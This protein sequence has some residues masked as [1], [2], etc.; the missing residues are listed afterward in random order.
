MVPTV[1]QLPLSLQSRAVSGREPWTLAM[2]ASS[3]RSV[4]MM[5]LSR[6]ALI[7]IL[8]DPGEKHTRLTV[9]C[10]HTETL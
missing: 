1:M 3:L 7:R 6:P 8:G 2:A 10:T 9:A 5:D 4:R